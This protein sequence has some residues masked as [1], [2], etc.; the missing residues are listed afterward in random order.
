VNEENSYYVGR[1]GSGVFVFFSPNTPDP[2][3]PLEFKGGIT[4]DFPFMTIRN[5]ALVYGPCTY[6]EACEYAED[7]Q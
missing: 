5:W 3:T 4:G 2:L 7:I 1:D 6:D